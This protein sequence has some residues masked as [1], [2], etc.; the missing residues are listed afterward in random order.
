MRTLATRFEGGSDIV[1]V[2]P[3][4]IIGAVVILL[5]YSV[6]V[7]QPLLKH[8]TFLNRGQFAKLGNPR[9]TVKRRSI[10]TLIQ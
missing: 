10:G 2:R 3:E 6:K 8:A 7:D 9:S 1:A 5:R 4:G